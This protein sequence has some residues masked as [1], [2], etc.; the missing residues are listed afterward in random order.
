MDL[1]VFDIIGRMAHF[2]KVF[3]NTTSLSYFFPPQT[4]VAGLIAGLLGF[5]RDSY[6][7]EFSPEK[8]KIAI[9]IIN[10]LRK[11]IQKVNYLNLD[12]VSEAILRGLRV[13]EYSRSP[14][15]IQLVLPEPPHKF[16]IYRVFVHHTN[17]KLMNKLEKILEQGGFA[18]P[19]CLGPAYC[20]AEVSAHEPLRV[21]ALLFDPLEEPINIS[22]VIKASRVVAIP[23]GT[24]L[25]HERRVPIFFS[26][27]RKLRKIDD[28][29]CQ[30]EGRPLERIQVDGEVF[31]C[32]GLPDGSYGVFME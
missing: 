10:P 26:N 8:C 13:G 14:T 2:R 12:D 9:S 19:P 5:E 28:Y 1:L 32:R 30:I 15:S 16:V 20:L 27:G 6:Y 4:T 24:R 25:C 31:S 3:S 23:Q 17:R 21:E 11:L 29:I 7:H 22:T 18:Y